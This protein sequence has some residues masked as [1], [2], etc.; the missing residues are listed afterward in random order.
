M[1]QLSWMHVVIRPAN[2]F[3]PCRVVERFARLAS[4][5]ACCSNHLQILQRH[6]APTG[7]AT[8]LMVAVTAAVVFAGCQRER[9]SEENA[10]PKPTDSQHAPQHASAEP[11]PEHH[12][13]EAPAAPSGLNPVQHEM[14]LLHQTMLQAVTA[15]GN[16][17]VRPVAESLHVLHGAKEQTEKALRAGSYTPPRNGDALARFIQL[18]E[19][20]HDRLAPLVAKSKENDVAGAAAALGKVLEACHGCHTEFRF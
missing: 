19:Q 6:R 4:E 11:A 20:F 15:I 12:H 17:D 14:R 1:I 10:N 2:A 18:D 5:M 13:G 3:G 7:W 16:G 8:S 9:G